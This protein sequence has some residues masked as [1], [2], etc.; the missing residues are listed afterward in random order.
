MIF[1]RKTAGLRLFQV[2]LLLLIIALAGF[3][4]FYKL[5]NKGLFFHDE[6][7][8]LLEA[9]FIV[10]GI[11]FLAGNFTK[12]VNHEISLDKCFKGS[13]IDLKGCPPTTGRI[14]HDILTALSMFVFQDRTFA[15]L[16]VSALFGVLTVILIFFMGRKM[17]NLR[18]AFFASLILAV[19]GYHVFFSRTAYAETDSVFFFILAIY[20]YYLSK[21]SK[22]RNNFLLII[23]GL[24]SGCAVL[25]NWRWVIIPA[26]FLFC[27]LF[28]FKF[29]RADKK[30]VITGN[31]GRIILFFIAFAV[32]LIGCQL[33]YH[34]LNSILPKSIGLTPYFD[35]V[36]AQMFRS[37]GSI[38]FKYPFLYFQFIYKLDG[39]V[40]LLLIIS[41][42]L[43]M[44]KNM[45]ADLKELRLKESICKGKTLYIGGNFL[46][47]Y[48]VIIICLLLF[49]FWN[50]YSQ[51][52]KVPRT[53]IIIVPLYALIAGWTMDQLF[54]LIEKRRILR[55]FGVLGIILIISFMFFHSNNKN[56]YLNS[57][58]K[59]AMNFIKNK[60]NKKHISTF[61]PISQFYVGKKNAA[62]HLWGMD[63]LKRLYLDGYRYIAFDWMKYLWPRGYEQIES[64]EENFKPV[65]VVDNII[66]NNEILLCDLGYS[67]EFVRKH[68]NDK[69]LGLI[70]IYDLQEVFKDE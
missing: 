66:G 43:L 59:E 7:A 13:E 6:G 33:I 46:E 69:D 24:S 36:F 12:V 38:S 17:F 15:G 53:I 63:N 56:L 22:K 10:S 32:P 62:M 8:Y 25:S 11:K 29:V 65:F 23:A 39:P 30:T 42:C 45:I 35:Q 3:L 19:S 5:N 57:G 50:F 4:R 34:I 51:Q 37:R 67:S 16:F 28:Y 26:V 31:P 70:K 61:W 9:E 54:C 58:Y 14:G 64:I 68:K 18:T 52:V 41:G 49:V 2:I 27:E 47:K 1:N 44:I 55:G 20:I 48:I 60:D 40:M 21:I